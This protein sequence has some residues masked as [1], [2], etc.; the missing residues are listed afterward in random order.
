GYYAATS[1]TDAQIGKVLAALDRSGAA[2]RTIVVLW[3]DHG[4]HLGDHGMWCKHSNYEQA[5]RIPVIISAP[6]A[7]RGATTRAMFETVDIYPTLC[8]LAG[9]AAPSGL[10]GRSQAAV[11]RDPDT[12]VREFVT[13]VYPRNPRLGRAI[14]DAR[15]RFVEWKG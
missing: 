8:E 2:D 3:G 13:H 4:W 9:I 10:D 14:R 12:R 5:A 15:Y 7:P 11:V 1:Y 6:G